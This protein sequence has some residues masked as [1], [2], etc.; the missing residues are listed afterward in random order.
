MPKPV[1]SAPTQQSNLND[2]WGGKKKKDAPEQSNEPS[3][4]HV[5]MDV[6]ETAVETGECRAV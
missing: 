5:K 3:R 2:M 4:A 6:N 1:K